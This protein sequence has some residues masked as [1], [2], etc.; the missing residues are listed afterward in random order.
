MPLAEVGKLVEPRISATSVRTI[1]AEHGLFRRKAKKVPRLTAGHRAARLDWALRYEGWGDADPEW[2]FVIWS[3]ECYVVMGQN[4]GTVWVTRTADEI[5]DDDCTI[6]TDKQAEIR[7]MVWGC[8]MKGRKG[9]LIVLDYPGGK[10]GGMTAQ[11]YREQ[12]LEGALLGFYQEMCTERGGE[13]LFQQ[14]GAPSH[15]AKATTNWLK[16]YVSHIAHCSSPADLI[17]EF[18]HNIRMFPHPP[19]S[20]DISPIE[21]LW[22]IFK[23]IIRSRPHT[24]TSVEELKVAAFEAWAA[25]TPEQLASVFHMQGRIQALI[26]QQGGHTKY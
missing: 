1:L 9:P 18:R 15:K 6:P 26:T 22:H 10:G 4:P 21:E 13:I 24:P 19:Q 3:D 17:Y 8:I 7:I 25:I 5:W 12:V 23:N 2:D 16:R 20:P 11:R 14:D